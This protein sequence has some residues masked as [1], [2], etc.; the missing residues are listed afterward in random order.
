MYN[1]KTKFIFIALF[2]LFFANS[3]SADGFLVNLNFD[4]NTNILSFDK[5]AKKDVER[6]KNIEASIV[7]FSRNQEQGQYILKLYDVTGAEFSSTEFD[8][9]DG[10][11][12]LIIPYFSVA[13]KMSIIQKSSNKEILSKDLSEFVSCN[14]NGKCEADLGESFDSCMS[15]CIS[16]PRVDDTVYLG[17]GSGADAPENDQIP[18]IEVKKSLWQK[19]LD[20]F[21]NLFSF[22]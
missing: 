7:E 1:Y 21:K 10:A 5:K 14:G 8:K 18:V 13:A 4:P 15:D 17:E 16:N 22:I 12:Q 19:I 20:F 2:C 6:D 3:A 11:F 9:K